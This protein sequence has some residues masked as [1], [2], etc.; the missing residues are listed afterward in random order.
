MLSIKDPTTSRPGGLMRQPTDPG[1]AAPQ[2]S[3]DPNES[4]T[5]GDDIAE[6]VSTAA[7]ATPDKVSTTQATPAA[8]AATPTKVVEEADGDTPSSEETPSTNADPISAVF[9]LPASE[10]AQTTQQTTGKSPVIPSGARN[11]DEYPEEVRP[12]L[13]GL[14]N[15]HF[16]EY[17]PKLKE[18]A[19]R[20]K[21][22]DELRA[23]VGQ[24]PQF[25]YEH[26]E[27]YR[28]SPEFQS[29]SQ[30]VQYIDFES[31]HYAEQLAR[32]KR[33]ESWQ[34]IAGYD[35]RTGQPVFEERKALANGTVNY[36]DEVRVGQLLT[37]LATL[38]S[39]KSS[40]LQ[41]YQT[42]YQQ[43]V[44]RAQVELGEVNKRLFPQLG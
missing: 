25:F 24:S 2:R 9:D 15:K 35:S 14:N 44:Q 43:S 4:V 7:Q 33:G 29:L 11:Y 37:K 42:S 19:Q 39:Q 30:D 21:E 10:T 27:A 1:P 23:K 22:A 12:V 40:Q 17:A 36:N 16:A 3:F 18:L 31:N 6:P 5:F 20:A 26:P 41:S 32:I 34:E 28:L 13:R 8:K 38:G